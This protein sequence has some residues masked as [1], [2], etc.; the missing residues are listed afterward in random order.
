MPL[1]GTR[2]DEKGAIVHHS[3]SDE[4]FVQLIAP[5]RHLRQAGLLARLFEPGGEAVELPVVEIEIDRQGGLLRGAGHLRR[6]RSSMKLSPKRSLCVRRFDSTR[7]S[8]IR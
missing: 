8:S 7:L 1:C 3:Q 6:D 4:Q 5:P 2:V